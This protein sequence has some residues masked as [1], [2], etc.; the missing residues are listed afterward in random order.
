MMMFDSCTTLFVYNALLWLLE[1]LCLQGVQYYHGRRKSCVEARFH[2][3]SLGLATILLPL[4]YIVLR[5]SCCRKG[6]GS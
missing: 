3:Q 1:P 4:C 5:I 2:E 6:L